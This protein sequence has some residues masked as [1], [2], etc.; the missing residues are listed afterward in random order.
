MSGPNDPDSYFPPTPEPDA[1]TAPDYVTRDQTVKPRAKMS[2]TANGSANPNAR[3]V[4]PTRAGA[5][6]K[7]T[8]HLGHLPS[9][10]EVKAVYPRTPSKVW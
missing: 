1:P 10:K 4:S 6:N 5:P 8:L 2:E 3:G 7:V 9:R